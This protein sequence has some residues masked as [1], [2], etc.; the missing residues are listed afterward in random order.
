MGVDLDCIGHDV[1]LC[2]AFP[3]SQRPKRS[4]SSDDAVEMMQKSLT[5]KE[6]AHKDEKDDFINKNVKITNF[7]TEKVTSYYTEQDKT[8][9]RRRLSWFRGE[10][11]SNNVNSNVNRA[12]VVHTDSFERPLPHRSSKNDQLPNF[13]I[14]DGMDSKIA[15]IKQ[16]KEEEV[17]V[18][19]FSS[20]LW[21]M[22]RNKTT[23]M[24][25]DRSTQDNTDQTLCSRDDLILTT[26]RDLVKQDGFIKQVK[27]TPWLR[28]PLEPLLSID[29]HRVNTWQRLSS[30]IG[31]RV[32]N[33]RLIEKLTPL[34]S[35]HKMIDGTSEQTRDLIF[36][37]TDSFQE[38]VHG[39]MNN[40]KTKRL[41]FKAR[42]IK[43]YNQLVSITG[44]HQYKFWWDVATIFMTIVSAY[45]THLD[46]RSR[47]F[48]FNAIH[49]FTRIWFTTDIL[50]NF[51][52]VEQD[53]DGTK[54]Q[55]RMA[56]VAIYLTTWFPIDILSIYPWE[57]YF[58]KP[59]I[60]KQNQRKFLTKWFFRS[61]ATVKVT[62]FLRGRHFKVFG[63]I[64]KNTKRLG[65]GAKKLFGLLVR[66][67]PKYLLFYKNMKTVIILRILRQV[68]L[69]RKMYVNITS[70]PD[71]INGQLSD[72]RYN[73]D[74]IL[75]D[76][77]NFN[78]PFK[79]LLTQRKIEVKLR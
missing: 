12:K 22:G 18:S 4:L 44:N 26:S 32:M 27:S 41:P 52:T 75:Y 29:N 35:I 15:N 19:R 46:I 63:R 64:A 40:V 65:Y 77:G 6:Q 31:I 76:E 23:V 28:E 79:N 2:S 56:S 39:V 54:T 14:F 34:P 68:N 72:R 11:F 37:R 5:S 8:A 30:P 60:E 71:P 10:K 62:R 33:A 53:S 70:D 55:N 66:Y 42:E 74:G 25:P 7:C 3:P 59:V 51:I 47:T 16:T 58:L 20:F 67:V 48:E 13:D 69:L 50:L 61:R 73:E 24:I 21:A 78:K 57:R 43:Q 45:T 49:I 17:E 1:M 9:T 36:R 38:Y